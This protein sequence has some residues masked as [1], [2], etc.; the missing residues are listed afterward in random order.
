MNAKPDL[1]FLVEVTDVFGA[2]TSPWWSVQFEL[3]S[4]GSPSDE[5]TF[6]SVA[7]WALGLSASQY[8]AHRPP[9]RA[10]ESTP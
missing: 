3:L 7:E 8:I 6:R 9:L 2:G 1:G 4:T 10:P 5:E